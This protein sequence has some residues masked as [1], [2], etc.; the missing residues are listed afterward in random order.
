MIIAAIVLYA[1]GVFSLFVAVG[2]I[3]R[4]FAECFGWARNTGD[5]PSAL[6]GGIILL[7]VSAGVFALASLAWSAA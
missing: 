1:L 4:V 6:I 2:G 7:G 3:S 5:H